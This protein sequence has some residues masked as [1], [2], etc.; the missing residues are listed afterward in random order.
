MSIQIEKI[1]TA[2]KKLVI[3]I[4]LAFIAPFVMA[5]PGSHHHGQ[6]QPNPP[7]PQPVPVQQHPQQLIHSIAFTAANSEE[8]VL[9]V[10]GDIVNRKA[11]NYV[12]VQNL[13][14]NIHDIYVVL[15]RPVDKIT[16]IKYQPTMLV[17]NFYVSYNRMTGM[18]EL[19]PLQPQ[20]VT[21]QVQPP[22]VCTFEEVERM[23]NTLKKESFDD[24]RLSMAK[25][26]VASNNMAAHQIKRL[27]ESFSFD[28]NK[29]SFLK[30]AYNHCIDRQN[31]YECV[32]VLIF[33][34]DKEALLR[35][36]NN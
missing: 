32:D 8:F 9:Y 6:H 34:S 35:Y 14:P 21:P 4:L 10:D 23:Y 7:H 15:K 30:Y 20:P 27:A 17:E 18:I 36:I 1:N 5:Q 25:N 13:T 22:H 19:M 12:L 24:T 26:M 29:L 28:K 16:M 33:S 11:S 31:Y 3:I 2:M